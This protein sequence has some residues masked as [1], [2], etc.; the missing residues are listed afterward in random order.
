M[1]RLL[2]GGQWLLGPLL[3]LWGVAPIHA[4]SPAPSPSDATFLSTLGELR[5]ASYDDKEG[6]VERLGQTGHPSVRAVLMAFQEDRLYFRGTD[7]RVF[8]V[9]SGD[10]D[11]LSLIDPVSL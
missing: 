1:K 5:E 11:P 3:A 8:I 2:W 7:Q 4:Q 10:A 6:I 9:K